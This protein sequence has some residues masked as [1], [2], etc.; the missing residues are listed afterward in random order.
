M[1]PSARPHTSNPCTAHALGVGDTDA[2]GSLRPSSSA[3]L[4]M[5]LETAPREQR[6]Q[7]QTPASPRQLPGHKSRYLM[8]IQ[9]V[10][11]EVWL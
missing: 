11:R 6:H 8:T 4:K 10:E 3:Q 1:S 2:R 7:A 9:M 5:H